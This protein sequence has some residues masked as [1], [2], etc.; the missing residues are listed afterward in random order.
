MK[1][2][3]LKGGEFPHLITV[4]ING[5]VINGLVSSIGMMV[6]KEMFDLRQAISEK[7]R[8]FAM[9]DFDKN[10]IAMSVAN[11]RYSGWLD[12]NVPNDWEITTL[13]PATTPIKVN[14]YQ[15]YPVEIA[16][17]TKDQAMLFKLTY[18]NN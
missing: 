9:L 6:F 14:R 4:E 2:T 8:R 7:Y 5:S 12:S 16:F 13:I 18:D 17:R 11:D 3:E 1:Y 10:G 15:P